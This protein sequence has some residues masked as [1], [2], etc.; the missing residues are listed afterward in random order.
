M[1]VLFK[2]R[3]DINSANCRIGNIEN[4]KIGYYKPATPL[5]RSNTY[6]INKNIKNIKK[7]DVNT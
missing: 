5:D 2:Y 1:E 7:S 4:E 6:D 3:A